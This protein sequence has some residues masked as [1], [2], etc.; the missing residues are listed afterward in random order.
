MILPVGEEC[1]P[2]RGRSLPFLEQSPGS[3]YDIFLLSAQPTLS[4]CLL[5]VGALWGF[6]GAGNPP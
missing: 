3:K 2:S 5:S 1:S 6:P 4:A